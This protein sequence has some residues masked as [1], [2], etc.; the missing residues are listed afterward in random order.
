MVSQKYFSSSINY[1]KD[2]LKGC[3]LDQK[4]KDLLEKHLE[5]KFA[6]LSAEVRRLTREARKKPNDKAL[7]KQRDI[8]RREFWVLKGHYKIGFG[9]SDL[10]RIAERYAKLGLVPC[11]YRFAEFWEVHQKPN[12]ERQLD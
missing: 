1:A 2:S 4:N 10:E 12:F 9:L 11:H 3:D 7:E 8:K 5:E 6:Q